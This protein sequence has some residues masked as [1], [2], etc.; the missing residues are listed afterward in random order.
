MGSPFAH[1]PAPI[2]FKSIHFTIF[3]TFCRL[4]LLPI[5]SIQ[6]CCCTLPSTAPH[7]HRW[8]ISWP[9]KIRCFRFRHSSACFSSV[10]EPPQLG[11]VCHACSPLIL[12]TATLKHRTSRLSS[13][14]HQCSRQWRQPPPPHPLPPPPPHRPAHHPP[15]PW[16]PRPLPL[17]TLSSLFRII[18]NI[19]NISSNISS[20]TAFRFP[21]TSINPSD[22][23][24]RLDISPPDPPATSC[25]G[26]PPPPWTR[27]ANGTD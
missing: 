9:S 22:S 24:I 7:P 2:T 18:T 25:V 6:H 17:P 5:Q 4:I 20:S 12:R 14:P 21:P 23:T 10:P 27:A 26:L 16:P 11:V 19:D 3:H 15:H 8:I 13:L 1:H